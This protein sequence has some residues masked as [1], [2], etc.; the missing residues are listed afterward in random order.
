MLND[1]FFSDLPEFLGNIKGTS[2]DWWTGIFYKSG[3]GIISIS[4]YRDIDRQSHTATLLWER[5]R[6]WYRADTTRLI[7]MDDIIMQTDQTRRCPR[8]TWGSASM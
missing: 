7:L 3:V 5:L 6:P 8:V 4:R 1:Q 2:E